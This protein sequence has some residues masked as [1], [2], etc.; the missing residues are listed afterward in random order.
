MLCSICRNRMKEQALTFL[1]ALTSTLK[2]RL[3]TFAISIDLKSCFSRSYTFFCYI[4]QLVKYLHLCLVATSV[5]Q[6]EGGKSNM[7]K[8]KSTTCNYFL[9]ARVLKT[10]WNLHNKFCLITANSFLNNVKLYS[11][12][13]Q[14]I[15]SFPTICPSF[16]AHTLN[17]T[18][19]GNCFT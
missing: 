9:D 19:N 11:F 5:L 4:S 17:S 10:I 3:R 7:D 1:K 6:L 14:V 15:L 8:T 13:I 12:D 18:C 16:S 2:A